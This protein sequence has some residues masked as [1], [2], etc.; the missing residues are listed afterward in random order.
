MEN[1]NKGNIV[2]YQSNDGLT[3]IDVKFEDETLWLTQQQMAEL[4]KTSR[5]NVVEHIKHIYEEGELDESS[6][7]RNFR[8]VQTE[9]KRQ[10]T[11]ELPFYNLDM[12]IS[13]GYRVKSHVATQF[14]RWA[15]ELL[16]E[17]LKKGYALDDKR[18]KELG[19]GDYWKE[20]L[21]RIRDI[22][23][24][25]KVMYRQ[26]LDLYATSA[27]YN[28][29]SAESI[30]FF[31]MVQNK[32]HY[33]AHGNTAA[34]VIYNRADAEKKFI[35]LTTFSGDFPTKKDVA[36]AKNYLDENELKVLNN[37]VSAYFDLAEINAMEHKKMY[38]SDYVEQLD[39]VIKT[40][41]KNLL[42]NAGSISHKQAIE[43]AEGEYQRFIQKNLSPVEESYLDTIREL[44]KTAKEN[45]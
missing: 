37:L 24:S 34:E 45:K 33:A 7:C 21:D 27:D 35:G 14:R 22:R 38:M 25:E 19:G 30:A 43:K 20:L 12:I 18:L 39:N 13:L 40:T 11:R 16:K 36:I 8:Q 15:T 9:G 29:K 3:K 6:T 44:N 23:S 26:V 28:P 41:G 32:L 5:T 17:Y 31:K 42:D 2:I 1:E 10:V 4:Y